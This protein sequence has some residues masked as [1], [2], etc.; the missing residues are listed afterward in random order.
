MRCHVCDKSMTEAEI[1]ESPSGIG[2][3]P[4]SVC[5]EI[6]LETAYSDGFVREEPL[7]E[8]SEMFADE[9]NIVDTLDTDIHRSTFDLCY[10]GING[11]TDDPD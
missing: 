8:D 10:V 5:M 3:E 2:Y 1:M 6:I 9:F 7:D 11:L 4:C